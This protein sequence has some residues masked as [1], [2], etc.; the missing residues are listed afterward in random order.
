MVEAV[1]AAA[2]EGV[3]A[4]PLELEL[5]L[6]ADHRLDARDHVLGL[7]LLLRVGLPAELEVDAEDVVGLAVQ[8]HRLV[9]V[10]GRVEPEPALGGEVRLHDHVGDQEAVHEDLA[11]DVQPEHGADRAARTVGDHQPVGRERVGAVGRLHA[12]ARLVLAGGDRDHVVL[13][14]HLEVR[15]LARALHKV[16]LE[17][18]LLQV[19]HARSVMVGLGAEV[20]VEH[21]V[22]TEE[23]AADVPRHALPHHLLAAAEAVEHL[24][25]ALGVAHAARADRHGV[26]VVEQQHRPP[27]AGEVDRGA[28]ADRAGTDDHHRVVPVTPFGELGRT[29]VVELGVLVRAQHG[30]LLRSFSFALE[31][32]LGARAS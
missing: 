27:L 20:E 26:V 15:E 25:R 2:L 21:L 4:D 1:H 17:V 28:Q 16:V 7:L 19:D 11:V 13:E 18:V 3:H 14:A 9:G 12:Q 22:L 6:I 10:E 29:N 24:E 30:G 31:P 32:R 5:A 8:Q 23:G